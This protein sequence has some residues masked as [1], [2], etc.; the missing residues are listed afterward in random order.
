MRLNTSKGVI[1]HVRKGVMGGWGGG[2]D[3]DRFDEDDMTGLGL[4]IH[5]SK[6]VWNT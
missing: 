6:P 2:G 5:I 3:V 4:G 1:L